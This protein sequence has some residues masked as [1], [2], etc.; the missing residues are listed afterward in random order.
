MLLLLSDWM[1]FCAVRV[2][3]ESVSVS[4]TMFT[5]AGILLASNTGTMTFFEHGFDDTRTPCVRL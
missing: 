2:V 3:G 5:G 1:I 4:F